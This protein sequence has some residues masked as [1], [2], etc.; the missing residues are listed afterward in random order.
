M[1]ALLSGAM[2]D[3]KTGKASQIGKITGVQVNEGEL[4]F[5]WHSRPP[6]PM[7]GAWDGQSIPRQEFSQRFQAHLLK[8]QNAEKPRYE[9]YEAGS[10]LGTLTGAELA[11]GADTR[12]FPELTTNRR[13]AELLKLIRQRGRLLTDA[14]LSEIGHKRP[15]MSQ[16]QPLAAATTRADELGKQISELIKEIPLELRL[17]EAHP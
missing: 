11:A 13:G 8:V 3:F 1:P 12:R 4:Q 15:G 6:L 14:W 9:L 2:V 17:V 16:G 7:D 10:L 5:I